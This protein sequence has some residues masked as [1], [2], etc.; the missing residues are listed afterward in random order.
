[1][2]G[3]ETGRWSRTPRKERVCRWGQGI[4]KTAQGTMGQGNFGQGEMGQEKFL[5]IMI[6]KKKNP[7]DRPT[8][9][10]DCST[11]SRTTDFYWP[12]LP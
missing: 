12:W 7:T 10:T 3:V 4:Q 5:D 8:D 11:V 2:L 9:P 6:S 1:M